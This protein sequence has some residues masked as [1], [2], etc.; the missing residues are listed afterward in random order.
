MQNNFSNRKELFL[1]GG[2]FLFYLISNLIMLFSSPYAWGADGYYYAAQMRHYWDRGGFFSND[3]SLVIRYLLLFSLWK[4]NYVV[5]NKIAVALLSS[6]IFF[7]AF[8]LGK[9]LFSRNRAFLFA[10]LLLSNS[11][12]LYFVTDYVKNLGGIF[13]FLFFVHALLDL[14]ERPRK[15]SLWFRAVLFFA[16]TLFSHK[17]MGGLAISLA[18]LTV[19]TKICS[20]LFTRYRTRCIHQ[21]KEDTPKEEKPSLLK[22]RLLLLLVIL[23]GALIIIGWITLPNVLHIEDFSRIN[24][25]INLKGQWPLRSYLVTSKLSIFCMVEAVVLWLA[26]FIYLSSFF[27]RREWKKRKPV[28]SDLLFALIYGAASFPFLYFDNHDFAFRLFIIIFIPAGYFLTAAVGNFSKRALLIL[29]PLIVFYHI[30]SLLLFPYNR[31]MDFA[32]FD[33][34]VKQVHLPEDGLLICHPGMDNFYFYKTGI[35]AFRFLPEPKHMDRPL[36]RLAH[37]FP[38]SLWQEYLGRDLVKKLPG[39]YYFLKESDWQLFLERLPMEESERYLDWKN[40][41]TERPAFMKRNDPE[42]Q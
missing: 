30:A 29:F 15:T 37:G 42:N 5:S 11:L 31:S 3:S 22:S 26:P 27:L 17:L 34:V 2:L 40:P 14:S 4:K 24:G 6:A 10:G 7:P 13:F 16:L 21:K 23:I 38:D 9:K 12:L 28:L 19:C 1:I 32:T 36:Y 33:R 8:S 39:D 41:F 25:R 35:D 20:L 18:A